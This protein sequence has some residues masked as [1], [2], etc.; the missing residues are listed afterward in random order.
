M[1]SRRLRGLEPEFGIDINISTRKKG[2]SRNTTL[3][4]TVN[5]DVIERVADNSSSIIGNEQSTGQ[6]LTPT[7]RRDKG[8]A[9]FDYIH[10]PKGGRKESKRVT[11]TE[12]EDEQTQV[13]TVTTQWSPCSKGPSNNPSEKARGNEVTKTQWSPFAKATTALD[14]LERLL[15]KNE[16]VPINSEDV[17]TPQVPSTSTKQPTPPKKTPTKEKSPKVTPVQRPTE[18]PP[19]VPIAPIDLFGDEWDRLSQ[20]FVLEK[21]F[22]TRPFS[23]VK[24]K[25]DRVIRRKS[26]VVTEH[27]NEQRANSPEMAHF[28][29]SEPA[30]Q[31]F[32]E[33]GLESTSDF[34]F[35]FESWCDERKFDGKTRKK[36]LIR[37]LPS[38]EGRAWWK[39]CMSMFE[40]DAVTWDQ[41]K[42]ELKDAKLT[43]NREDKLK[44]WDVCAKR[45]G[46]K[47]KAS[48]FARNMSFLAKKT[49]PGIEDDVL[50]DMV[51]NNMQSDIKRFILTRGKP[52]Q[53]TR[54]LNVISEYETE[55]L[56]LAGI[57]RSVLL[58]STD[59]D[60]SFSN[61]L[62]ELTKGL[63]AMVQAQDEKMEKIL[64]EV[65][66][67]K[68][69]SQEVEDQSRDQSKPSS[70]RGGRN[71]NFDNVPRCWVC[72]KPGHLAARCWYNG[73]NPRGR[74]GYRGQ[75]GGYRGGR[76]SFRG[77]RGGSQFYYNNNYQQGGYY[78][79]QY[80]AY[81][82]GQ[83]GGTDQKAL[84]YPQQYQDN[85]NQGN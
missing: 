72:N 52:K 10:T 18:P 20:I 33:T 66:L 47:E 75:R 31:F 26:I 4:S 63:E 43:S 12:S 78:P 49:M 5:S 42:Q 83:Q 34:L 57:K 38:A 16:T 1:S 7:V 48:T 54:L 81:E 74:G 13:K 69:G 45:Q 64:K 35:L 3:N 25:K 19:K 84:T 73:G 8:V 2:N 22:T 32:P 68:A 61:E 17:V 40:D 46:E 79:Q 29:S 67:T 58:T 23:G 15:N 59:G 56:G 55:N 77:G 80:E 44:F 85:Y 24:T 60:D 36:A 62:K 11:D 30:P 39:S 70:E 65:L 76:G 9:E 14:E 71:R 6:P 27:N 50:I 41:V 21:G 28:L 53:F 82:Q 37:S 51:V